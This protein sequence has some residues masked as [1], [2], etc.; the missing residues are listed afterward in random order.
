LANWAIE[1]GE[2][3]LEFLPRSAI[4]GQALVDFLGKF[5]NL[6]KTKAV[7]EARTWVIYIDGSSTRKHRGVGVMVVTPE[8]EEL[9][10]S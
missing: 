4:K 5:T 8:E 10:S 9:C 2:F 1:L 7:V 6:P 3:D